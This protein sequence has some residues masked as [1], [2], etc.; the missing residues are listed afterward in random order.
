MTNSRTVVEF[1]PFRLDRR[2]RRLLRDGKPVPLTGKVFDTLCVLVENSGHLVTKNQLLAAVWPNTIVEEENLSYTISVLRKALQQHRSEPTYIE[3]VPRQGYRFVMPVKGEHSLL[4]GDAHR[5]AMPKLFGREAEM[6]VL[7]DVFARSCAGTRQAVFVT[8]DA[9]MGKTSL[10]DAFVAEVTRTTEVAVARGECLQQRGQAEP[11]MP[12]LN[13]ITR[14]TSIAHD[15]L[16]DVLAAHAPTWLAQLPSLLRDGD[17]TTLQ[18]AQ[19]GKTRERM[20]REIMQAFSMLAVARPLVVILEDLHWCDYSTLDFVSMFCRQSTP[21]RLLLIATYRASDAKASFHPLHLEVRELKMRNCATEIPLPLMKPCDVH[22]WMSTRFDRNI[23]DLL[24][25]ILHTQTDGNPLFIEATV[26]NWLEQGQIRE[27]EGS[28]Q[29]NAPD[30]AL[31]PPAS[32]RDFLE[33]QLRTLAP[34][35][36]SILEAA[37]VA[38]THFCTLMIAGM[39]QEHSEQVEATCAAMSHANTFFHADGTREYPDG[40]V[41]DA[42]KFK[43]SLFA[44][45]IYSQLTAAQ[46]VRMHARAAELLERLQGSHTSDIAGEL[47]RHHAEAKNTEQALNYL[48]SA[49]KQAGL[50]CA[51]RDV[52]SYL[53]HSLDLLRS[54]PAGLQRDQREV[55]IQ[56]MRGPALMATRGFADKDAEF[57]FRRTIELAPTTDEQAVFPAV[58]GLA[59]MLEFRGDFAGCQ[60]LVQAYLPENQRNYRHIGECRQLLACSKFHQGHF[61]SALE[62]ALRG[63]DHF[64]ENLHSELLLGFGENGRVEC[65]A[66][67]ALSQW[68]LGECTQA[69]MSA[70]HALEIAQTPAHSYAVANAL[71]QVT[72]L[73]QFR[74]EPDLVLKYGEQAIEIGQ[75]QGIVYRVALGYALRGWARARVT[76]D[77]GALDDIRKG[78]EMAEGIGATLDR[79]Y[80]LALLAESLIL[81]GR[82]HEALT[83]L[84]AALT[85]VAQ[86]RSFFYEAELWRLQGL[87]LANTDA[88]PETVEQSFQHALDAAHGQQAKTLQLRALLSMYDT[89]TNERQCR[90]VCRMLRGTLQEFSEDLD[91][92]DFVRAKVIVRE[93]TNAPRLKA[94]SGRRAAVKW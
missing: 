20:L 76:Q 29:V 36:R 22:A 61:A 73:Y 14:V 69:V 50:R 57:A 12:L 16:H 4:S 40:S 3:T 15:D 82:A 34:L 72:V 65:H 63:L 84:A 26:Q 37:S 94:V 88:P 51:H 86:T 23:G 92:P 85:Q 10:V 79:P 9:G 32:L 91:T 56:S 17:D 19:L 45:T 38:G 2:E 70:M 5:D 59:A 25:P 31:D 67:A 8:G 60:R 68:F 27:H 43:H 90:Q 80:L 89:A 49:A 83:H 77:E 78:I 62:H 55:T 35:E 46:R 81:M 74:G 30:L 52:I 6:M 7:K 64:S 44:D 58:F 93:Y 41:C 1:G 71:A 28:W 18:R 75:Q 87:A 48:Q 53:D 39:L 24:A 47:A 54:V 21:A 42:Y 11:Y 66:W 33:Q 13:A